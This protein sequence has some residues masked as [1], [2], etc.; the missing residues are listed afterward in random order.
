MEKK[1]EKKNIRVARK[2]LRLRARGKEYF[3]SNS[4]LGKKVYELSGFR[5]WGDNTLYK[6]L[7]QLGIELSQEEN[8]II[9]NI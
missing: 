2:I 4:A 3:R 9:I 1:R 8:L 6:E 5:C 7:H